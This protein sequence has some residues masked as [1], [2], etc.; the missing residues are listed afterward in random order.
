[1]RR[2]AILIAALTALAVV[3]V[4]IAATRDE[5]KFRMA[6]TATEVNKS[7]GL[8][9]TTDRY[10]YEPPPPGKPVE[11]R[12]TKTVFTLHRG[13]KINTNVVPGCTAAKL[14]N[15]GPSACPKSEIGNGG[16]TVITGVSSLDPVRE[17]VTLFAKKD[18]ILAYLTG[19]QKQVISLAVDGRTITAKVPRICLGG[20]TPEEGCPNGEAVLQKL[21]A[22]VRAK[23]TRKGKL[24]KTPGTCPSS[25]RW[26]NKVKYSYSNGDTEVKKATSKCSR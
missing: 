24:V 13:A 2:T 25:R 19:L 6:F 18:G 4:A 5:H 22:K 21:V 20:G 14:M 17:D 9:F 3:S 23:R 12:V 26:T 15:T 1:M 7:T 10:A 8:N 11:V 16:A